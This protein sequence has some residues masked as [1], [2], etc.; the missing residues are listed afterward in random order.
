[1]KEEISMTRN[2]STLK[3]E[4]SLVALEAKEAEGEEEGEET[5][6]EVTKTKQLRYNYLKRKHHIQENTQH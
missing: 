5:P 2:Q 6:V 3:K 4:A 1:M